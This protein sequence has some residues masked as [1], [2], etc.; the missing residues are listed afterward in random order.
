MFVVLGAMDKLEV[1]HARQK[2]GSHLAMRNCLNHAKGG[3]SSSTRTNKLPW[4][5]NSAYSVL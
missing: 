2:Q 4:P 5:A 1:D 3:N